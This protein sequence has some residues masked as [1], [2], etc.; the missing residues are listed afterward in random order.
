MKIYTEQEKTLQPMVNEP[1]VS[2]HKAAYSSTEIS[3]ISEEELLQN[4]ITLE[5]SRQRIMERI[6]KDFQ[7]KK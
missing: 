5:E 6:H 1:I 2:Y 3:F 4:C 7:K